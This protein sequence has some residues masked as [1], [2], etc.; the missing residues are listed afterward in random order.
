MDEYE[1]I[2]IGLVICKKIVERY[3]GEIWV[4]LK[5]GYGSIFCFFLLRN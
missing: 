2:G 4:E 5:I 1:G 3:G